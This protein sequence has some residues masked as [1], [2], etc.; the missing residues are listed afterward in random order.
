M[1][2]STQWFKYQEGVLFHREKVLKS[3]GKWYFLSIR[4][5]SCFIEKITGS[6]VFFG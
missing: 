2:V 6:R 4:K 1:Y 5:V 3:G